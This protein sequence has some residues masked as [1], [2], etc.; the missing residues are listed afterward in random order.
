MYPLAVLKVGDGVASLS[1]TGAPGALVEMDLL[2][3]VVSYR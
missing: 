1:S 2:G 3:E